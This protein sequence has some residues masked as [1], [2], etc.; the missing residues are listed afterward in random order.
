MARIPDRPARHALPPVLGR[1]ELRRPREP[2][3]G[4]ACRELK[5]IRRCTS[6]R[7]TGARHAT[8]SATPRAIARSVVLVIRGELLKRYPNTIIYA[9]RPDGDDRRDAVSAGVVR[10]DRS[11]ASRPNLPDP[12]I[13]FPLYKA[14]VEP[15]IHFIGFDLTLDEVTRRSRS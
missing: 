8:T 11:R 12:N 15:D 9:Q 3:A 7:P 6:G 10:R 13:R 2:S 5:D 4:G 1:V 14:E